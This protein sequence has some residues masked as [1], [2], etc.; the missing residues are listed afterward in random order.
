MSLG[1][2]MN[3]NKLPQIIVAICVLHNIARSLNDEES[4]DEVLL[5]EP[6]INLNENVDNNNIGVRNFVVNNV[7]S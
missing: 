4:D 7:F 3:V 5:N 2:R 6:D 1:I